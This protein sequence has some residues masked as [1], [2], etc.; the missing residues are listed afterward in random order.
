MPAHPLRGL[1]NYLMQLPLYYETQFR[2]RIGGATQQLLPDR[3]AYQAATLDEQIEIK[4]NFPRVAQEILSVLIRMIDFEIRY[5]QFFD[6]CVHAGQSLSV[7]RHGK[8][9]WRLLLPQA[10]QIGASI[11]VPPFS[12]R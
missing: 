6:D 1:K 3:P 9:S 12:I 8:P 4:G 2:L 10:I 11:A 5:W 7:F